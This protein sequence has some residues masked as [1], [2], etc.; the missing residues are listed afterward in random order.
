M[1]KVADAVTQVIQNDQTALESFREGILNLSAYAEKIHPSIE[2]LVYKNVKKGTIIVALSRLSKTSLKSGLLKPNIQIDHL[3]TR[4]PLTSFTYQKT[5]DT[6]R[7]VATLNPYLVT[8]ADLFGIMEGETEIVIICSEKAVDL[9]KDHIGVIPKRETSGLVAITVQFPENLN[10]TPNVLYA[11]LS[12]LA[13]HKISV[14]NILP[15]LDEISFIIEKNHLEQAISAFN[16]YTL[17]EKHES[18]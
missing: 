10:L 8:P 13:V 16:M 17:K 9:I 1:L 12:T 11:L 5:F 18:K 3:N 14:V 2:K 6:Q 4:F 7:R 15:T